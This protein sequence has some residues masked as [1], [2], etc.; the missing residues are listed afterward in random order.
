MLLRRSMPR[1]RWNSEQWE[2]MTA[3]RVIGR[4]GALILGLIGVVVGLILDLT[5]LI[6]GHSTGQQTHGFLGLVLLLVGLIGSVLAVF[7]PVTAA[8][9]ML[10]AGIGFF[11][12]IGAGAI[13]V[14]PFFVVAAILAYLDRNPARAA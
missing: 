12:V 7:S 6:I 3:M 8:I 13:L 14:A 10:I 9:L 5:G 4:L 1:E 11:W 2:G